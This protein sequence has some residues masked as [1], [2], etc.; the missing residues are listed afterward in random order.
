MLGADGVSKQLEYVNPVSAL[1]DMA[2]VIP[3]IIRFSDDAPEVGS[4]VDTID[5]ATCRWLK[6]D[7]LQNPNC[8]RKLGDREISS[9]EA[10]SLF[11]QKSL[12]SV[13]EENP[14]WRDSLLGV[15]VPP[16]CND[17]YVVWLT[18]AMRDAGFDSFGII[19]EHTAA[20]LGAYDAIDPTATYMI[21][22]IGGGTTEISIVRPEMKGR[23]RDRCRVLARA[24]EE[25]G[26]S[27]IDR[28]LLDELDDGKGLPQEVGLLLAVQ[29][30]K[31]ALGYENQAVVS[32]YSDNTTSH[33]THNLER[34]TFEGM[35]LKRGFIAMMDGLIRRVLDLANSL[36]G[37]ASTDVSRVIPVGGTCLIPA[38]KSYLADCFGD[39]VATANPYTVVAK[40]ASLFGSESVRP[41]LLHDYFLKSWDLGNRR[42]AYHRL[43][44][45]GQT[46]PTVGPVKTLEIAATYDGQDRLAVELFELPESLRLRESYAIAPE[47]RLQLSD[48]A[49]RELKRRKPLNPDGREFILADPP[50]NRGDRRFRIEFAISS[51][52]WLT[53]SV[54]DKLPDGRSRLALSDGRE[55]ELP[56][57]D[58]PIV[59]LNG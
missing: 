44:G 51:D 56:V 25:V 23:G 48:D 53:V 2:D 40:G 43:A 9:S 24:K 29:E 7:L 19:D 30:A 46:I 14:A 54:V 34:A 10:A 28:W 38:I 39:R 52:K 57:V 50:C 59:Q 33:A 31:H 18:N 16:N 3:S 21:V 5:D 17:A 36:Y 12:A 20:I 6:L 41:I 49:G 47:G 45:R 26:G 27:T 1:A 32:F 15:S 58:T 4:G 8:R 22:D 35:L 13:L 11:L 55:L 37:I 42:D